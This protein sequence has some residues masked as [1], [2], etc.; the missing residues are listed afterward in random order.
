M[1]LPFIG[2]RTIGADD[3]SE[4]VASGG[5]TLSESSQADARSSLVIMLA[6]STLAMI[7]INSSQGH[8]FRGAFGFL[9]TVRSGLDATLVDWLG[10]PLAVGILFLIGLAGGAALWPWRK[11]EAKAP[12]ETGCNAGTRPEMIDETATVTIPEAACVKV[13][14]T[15]TVSPPATCP[16]PA[17]ATDEATA[18]AASVAEDSAMSGRLASLRSRALS[19]EGSTR[20]EPAGL[21]ASADPEPEAQS[22]GGSLGATSAAEP[23]AIDADVL[24]ALRQAIVFR[25][26]FPPKVEPG[27]SFYG[28][29][30]IAS[31]AFAWPCRPDGAPLHFVL[32]VDCSAIPAEAR[33]GLLPD[34][35]VLYFFVD[36]SWEDMDAVSVIHEDEPDETLARVTPPEALS[37]VFGADAR[38]SFAWINPRGSEAGEKLPRLLPC[39]PFRP[40]AIAL[41]VDERSEAER[42]WWRDCDA[43]HAEIA[44]VQDV[45]ADKHLPP[46]R[47]KDGSMPRPYSEFPHDWRAIAITSIAVMEKVSGHLFTDSARRQ[48]HDDDKIEALRLRYCDEALECLGWARSHKP[49]KAVAPE[50]AAMFWEWLEGLVGVSPHDI[51]HAAA[52]A[53]EATLSAAPKAARQLGPEALDLVRSR[54]ALAVQG[55]S[56]PFAPTPNRMLA[57]ASFV[58]GAL[59]DFVAEEVLLLELGAND[60]IGHAFGEG[61][62]QFTIRPEDLRARRFDKVRLTATAY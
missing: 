56:G 39:W 27:L 19:D 45:V 8:R 35:G 46:S 51:R 36:L 15:A 53:I 55:D 25:Q 47:D 41:P 1:Q 21:P 42:L 10:R 11:G 59:S 29:A 37:P 38:Y 28:G 7:A 62:Y 22:E 13:E 31:P 40:A 6:A 24:A 48:G 4:Q 60:P 33:L 26:E 57:P 2:R 12:A 23:S 49:F 30:P 3:P 34:S 32:Q 20:G 9:D 52:L 54:H 14:D 61:V 44:R 16:V 17:P 18:I 43:I 50:E 5:A 58:Q